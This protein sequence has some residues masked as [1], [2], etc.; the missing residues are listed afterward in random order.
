MKRRHVVLIIAL[1][2]GIAFALNAPM[3]LAKDL[4]K[5]ELVEQ[6]KSKITE[7]A[8]ADAKAQ[9]DK[10]G[11]VFLDCRE[12][13]EYKQG[14]IPGAINIPRGLLE[15]KIADQVPDK[16]AKIVMYCKS[17]GR[18]SLACCSLEP[19]GYKNVVSIQG[20]WLA[21]SKAGYPVE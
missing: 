13:N 17:G 2:I 6:A 4:T 14:H 20:G 7:I 5:K 10:G 18:A 19:M 9:F 11:A 12:P 16:N 15:F 3:A 1:A 21:W 8:V